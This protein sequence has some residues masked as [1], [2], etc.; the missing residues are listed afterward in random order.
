MSVEE[1]SAWLAVAKD[2]TATALRLSPLAKSARAAVS[3]I[4]TGQSVGI[5]GHRDKEAVAIL[6][7]PD[8]QD[9]ALIK[10][11]LDRITGSLANDL[12]E[13]DL[14]QGQW[15]KIAYSPFLRRAGELLS[16]FPGKYPGGLPNYPSTATAMLSSGLLGAGLGY[17]AGTLAETL[18]PREWERGKLRR[19]LAMMGGAAGTMPGLAL[20]LNNLHQGRG[21]ND[22]SYL[23]PPA[24]SAPQMASADLQKLSSI[25]L[26]TAYKEACA[27]YGTVNEL[28]LEELHKE[29]WGGDSIGEDDRRATHTPMDINVDAMGRTLWETGTDPAT[30][31][32]TMAVLNAADQM[33]GGQQSGWVTP[34]QMGELAARMGAGY[35][36]GALVGKALGLLAGLSPGTQ[37]LLARTGLYAGAVKALLPRVFNTGG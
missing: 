12:N 11:A 34:M 27:M 5:Y 33:P 30:A 20:G 16:F 7:T 9:N 13:T 18:Y 19:T 29:A 24:G 25:Q 28:L 17:G 23:A 10:S 14:G 21:F 22:L 35:V 8:P 1:M 2:A 36:S 32:L 31:G 3:G 37:D 26:G 4:L 6:P 15:V